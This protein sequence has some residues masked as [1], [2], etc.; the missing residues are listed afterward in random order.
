LGTIG[1]LTLIASAYAQS[2]H[3]TKVR[4]A[5]ATWPGFA[6]AYVARDIGFFTGLDADIQIVD[7]PTARL[8]AFRGD[9]FEVEISSLDVFAQETAGGA[10]GRIFM[11]TD[12]SDGADGL[13]S[14]PDVNNLGDLLG[15]T[16]AVARGSPSQFLLHKL[17]QQQRLDLNQVHLVFFQDPTLA[18]QAFVSGKVDAAVTWEP[19]MSQIV[20]EG[21]GKVLM[22]S[23]DTPDAI[24]DVLIGS[25]HFLSDKETIQKFI[26][27]WL[28]AAQFTKSNPQKA[29]PIIAKALGMTLTPGEDVMA[30]I[31]LA[32]L[33]QNKRILCSAPGGQ[34]LAEAT[35]R[36]AQ[37][38]W[39]AAGVIP[40]AGPPPPRLIDPFIC[41]Q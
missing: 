37:Q 40:A 24:V 5:S 32:D 30:G 8:A 1:F 33:S 3:Q 9:Q 18:G 13:V 16:I 11:I 15:H 12:R 14:R 19:L 28:Q 2:L 31:A 41:G 39:V 21:K 35:L 10:N 17:F 20:H 25:D 4:V 22:S 29:Y 38:F 36:D 6:V 34:S 23:A 7:D 27:G 26:H